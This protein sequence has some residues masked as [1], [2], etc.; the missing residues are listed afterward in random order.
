MIAP[1]KLGK[2]APLQLWQGPEKPKQSTQRS[3]GFWQAH[4]Q[5]QDTDLRQARE[6]AV[7]WATEMER[8]DAGDPQTTDH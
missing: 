5:L 1:G 8:E 3:G 2:A 4:K 6:K 7:L